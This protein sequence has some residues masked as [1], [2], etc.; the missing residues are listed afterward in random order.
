MGFYDSENV[1][2]LYNIEAD[3][4]IKVWEVIF[5]EDILGHDRLQRDY[6]ENTLI[7]GLPP[8]PCS[9]AEFDNDV[10]SDNTI[11]LVVTDEDHVASLHSKWTW[12]IHDSCAATKSTDMV[13]PIQLSPFVYNFKLPK[14]YK[15]AMRSNYTDQWRAACDLEYSAL[16]YNLTWSLVPH[17]ANTSVIQ[18]K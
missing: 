10:D 16:V 14:E 12:L 11:E 7:T 2:K 17:I 8:T 1:F 6:S 5:F 18:Y 4:I 15:S 3:A 13:L 9:D